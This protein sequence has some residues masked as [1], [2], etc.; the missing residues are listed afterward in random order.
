M[1]MT[2][3]NR[4]AADAV[5]RI[6]VAERDFLHACFFQCV[7]NP[8]EEET[9]SQ[10]IIVISFNKTQ[11]F[12]KEMRDINCKWI[13]FTVRKFSFT[14]FEGRSM[15]NRDFAMRNVF[16]FISSRSTLF[17]CKVQLCIHMH[18]FVH[19]SSHWRISRLVIL[20]GDFHHFNGCSRR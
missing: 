11:S 15:R 10:S 5:M 2:I 17:H 19:Y 3:A 13:L 4:D 12:S 18:A 9:F 8:S 16:Y 1:R 6:R 7:K 20:G 14:L